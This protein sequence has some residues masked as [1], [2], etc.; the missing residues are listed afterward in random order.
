VL[1]IVTKEPKMGLCVNCRMRSE[2]RHSVAEA[3]VWHCRDYC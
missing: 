2:C 1:S 3:G